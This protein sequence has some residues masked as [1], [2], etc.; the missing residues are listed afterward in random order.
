[1]TKSEET[2]HHNGDGREPAKKRKPMSEEHKRKISE[3]LLRGNHQYRGRQLSDEHKKK[4][5][6]TTQSTEFRRKVSERMK[7]NSYGALARHPGPT[8]EARK[9]LLGV[10]KPKGIDAVVN[11]A[12]EASDAAKRAADDFGLLEWCVTE[13][14]PAMRWLIV[15]SLAKAYDNKPSAV[16]SAYQ[17]YRRSVAQ[18]T[19]EPSSEEPA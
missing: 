8:D 6:E 15:H 9:A 17:A 11:A 12:L 7:G 13:I 5:R 4:I 18:K 1:M 19:K 3:A 16:F 10:P 14:S 2:N